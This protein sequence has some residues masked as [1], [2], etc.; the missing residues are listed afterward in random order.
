MAPTIVMMYS[1]AVT[2]RLAEVVCS[3]VA[4]SVETKILWDK[5]KTS[6]LIY[7]PRKCGNELEDKAIACYNEL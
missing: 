2:K 1:T 5:S 3:A 7:G 4:N 6:L